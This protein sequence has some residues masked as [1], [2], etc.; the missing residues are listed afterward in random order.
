MNT[1]IELV[2]VQDVKEFTDIAK[3]VKDYD[4]DLYGKDE[5]GNDWCLSAK[6]L[7]DSLTRS[8]RESSN[9]KTSSAHNVDWN[10][11]HCVCKKDIYSLISKFA[12]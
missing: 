7:Y 10:T 6:T 11:I 1:V 3:S 4:V 9:K 5:N 8:K 2:T 12:K